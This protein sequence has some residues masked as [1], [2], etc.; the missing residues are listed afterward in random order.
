MVV[1]MGEWERGK[2]KR[3]TSPPP[4]RPKKERHK[5]FETQ[6]WKVGKEH[7]QGLFLDFKLCPH[8]E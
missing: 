3:K 2:L 5:E 1:G 4:P 8:K 6:C 7:H